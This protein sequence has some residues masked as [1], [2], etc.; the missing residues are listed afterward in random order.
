MYWQFNDIWLGASWS[1]I[2]Y[3][4]KL[5]AMQ[6]VVRRIGIGNRRQGDNRNEIEKFKPLSFGFKFLDRKIKNTKGWAVFDESKA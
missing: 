5:K 1:G 3:F 6:Y 2:D 4:G